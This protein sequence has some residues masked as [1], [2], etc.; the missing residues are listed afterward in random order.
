[1]ERSAAALSAVLVT[2]PDEETGRRIAHRLVEGR[3]AACVNLV[4]GLRSIYRWQG[5]VREDPEVLLL[6][7]T[8][9]ERLEELAATIRELHP[10]EVPEIVALPTQAA[11]GPYLAWARET[12]GEG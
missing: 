11:D 9:P 6:V 10:Y 3:L 2:A 5:E 7:K 8:V 4:P 1:M 12:V